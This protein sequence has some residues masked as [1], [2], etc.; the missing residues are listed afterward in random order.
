LNDPELFKEVS[1]R[2]RDYVRIILS[3]APNDMFAKYQAISPVSTIDQRSAF[4][5]IPGVAYDPS[6]WVLSTVKPYRK[7]RSCSKKIENCELPVKLPASAVR[8]PSSIFF[9]TRSILP[10][11]P[12]V[13]QAMYDTSLFV[14][15][16]LMTPEDRVW[17]DLND[18][19]QYMRHE[20]E[21]GRA[22]PDVLHQILTERPS[23]THPVIAIDVVNIL[24]RE[25]QDEPNFSDRDA[26]F[27]A[28]AAIA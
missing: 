20:L 17:Q 19:I 23:L 12:Y 16:S 9:P 7:V 11:V 5:G 26:R 4:Y 21:R 1:S 24:S 2:C 25:G 28:E 6:Q 22:A 14:L 27:E 15:N 18:G 3:L 10:Y 13:D 8:P